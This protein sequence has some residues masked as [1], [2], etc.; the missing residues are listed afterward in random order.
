MNG[1]QRAAELLR[2][3]GTGLSQKEA[4]Q[5]LGMSEPS[6]SKCLKRWRNRNIQGLALN[7]RTPEVLQRD[8]D[9]ADNFLAQ[10]KKLSSEI[11]EI[12]ALKDLEGSPYYEAKSRLRKM[13]E[14]PI[15]S[16]YIKLCDRWSKDAALYD[17]LLE[18]RTTFSEIKKDMQTLVE[19][20][21]RRVD[22][23]TRQLIMR[24]IDDVRSMRA[25]L[26]V[27]QDVRLMEE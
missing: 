26:E 15:E 14:G 25:A 21:M 12:R 19:I 20:I 8:I 10:A 22:P 24:D 6:V 16:H 23:E 17:S 3:I 9:I 2:L 7:P 4:G 11:E 13:I 5:V 27:K 1:E 18:K